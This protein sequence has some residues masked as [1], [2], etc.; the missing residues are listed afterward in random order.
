MPNC[1]SYQQL[2]N[3]ERKLLIA[4]ISH[5]IQNDEISFQYAQSLIKRA[6]SRDVFDSVKFYPSE[7]VPFLSRNLIP[8]L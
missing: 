8:T 1:E 6:E 7:E 3:E 2:S 5:A 4:K